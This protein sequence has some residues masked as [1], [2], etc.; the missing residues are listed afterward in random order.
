VEAGP[1][2]S[3][4]SFGTKERSI[5]T[6]KTEL[7]TTTDIMK[8]KKTAALTL[9]KFY[10]ESP[11]S[12]AFPLISPRAMKE[13]TSTANV[14]ARALLLFNPRGSKGS[15]VALLNIFSASSPVRPPPLG[16][17]S[18]PFRPPFPEQH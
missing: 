4:F 14:V 15:I 2:Q 7:N 8:K 13:T 10:A 3:V 6:T 11:I 17:R 12:K 18:E 9:T 16:H 1:G 5:I